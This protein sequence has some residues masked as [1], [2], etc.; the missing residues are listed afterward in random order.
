[1]SIGVQRSELRRR[2]EEDDAPSRNMS[3]LW[4]SALLR[5]RVARAFSDAGEERRRRRVRSWGTVVWVI[6]AVVRFRSVIRRKRNA[7]KRWRVAGIKLRAAGRFRRSLSDEGSNESSK[8]GLKRCHLCYIKRSTSDPPLA[9]Q[10]QNSPFGELIADLQTMKGVETPYRGAEGSVHVLGRSATDP[11]KQRGLVPVAYVD[12]FLAV[13]DDGAAYIDN[14]N[15]QTAVFVDDYDEDEDDEEEDV[16]DVQV[17]FSPPGS[18]DKPRPASLKNVGSDA[19]PGSSPPSP[20]SSSS[21]SAPTSFLS[22]ASKSAEKSGR[23]SMWSCADFERK[24]KVGTGG[25]GQVYLV[26]HC[27]TRKLY[28]MKVLSK[29]EIIARKRFDRVETERHILTRSHQSGFLTHLQLAFHTDKALFF[30]ME[31]CSGGNLHE[32]MLREHEI[33]HECL[34]MDNYRLAMA[35]A[36]EGHGLFGALSLVKFFHRPDGFGPGKLY[37]KAGPE[38]VLPA[39]GLH[40]TQVQFLAAEILLGLEFLHSMGV[41][42]RDLKPQNVLLQVDGHIRIADFGV[43]KMSEL[44]D[45]NGAVKLRSNSFVGTIEYMSPEVVSGECQTSALDLWGLGI[46]VYELLYG[47]PPFLTEKFGDSGEEAD[48]QLFR[49]ILNPDVHLGFARSEDFAG[50]MSPGSPPPTSPASVGSPSFARPKRTLALPFSSS[51]RDSAT[52]EEASQVARHFIS[53]L[54][55]RECCDR[56]TLAQAKSHPFFIGTEWDKLED[57]SGFHRLNPRIHLHRCDNGTYAKNVRRLSVNVPSHNIFLKKSSENSV[58]P[59]YSQSA[60]AGGASA[61]YQS[62]VYLGNAISNLKKGVSKKRVRARAKSD[63]K[64]APPNPEIRL[65]RSRSSKFD[66]NPNGE[67]NRNWRKIFSLLKRGSARKRGD[68]STSS[69]GSESIGEAECGHHTACLTHDTLDRKRP[70]F[71]L[72]GQNDSESGFH[73]GRSDEWVAPNTT[74]EKNDHVVEEA[75]FNDFDWTFEWKKCT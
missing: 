44:R 75:R 59:V 36:A 24:R 47:R 21:S 57:S 22:T 74:K 20:P 66:L 16:E 6:L 64:P 7:R 68:D 25:S 33:K 58:S 34:S 45:D 13:D 52:P 26:Q 1:M 65:S 12:E 62:S 55:T 5:V 32:V 37:A 73:S 43:S 35:A 9:M 54:L 69:G 27:R 40:E 41:V 53:S 71:L 15:D 49:Q 19:K 2:E 60:L 48:R 18:V 72:K 30:V 11:L 17:L 29:A 46:L 14:E 8:K 38:Q 10:N 51:R 61:A 56:L 50:S 63:E 28:A 3:V 39:F 70:D 67:R 4:R 23:R 31:Y 42:Y